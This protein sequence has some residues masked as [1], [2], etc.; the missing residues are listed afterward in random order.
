MVASPGLEPGLSALRGRR[1]NQLH[2]DAKKWKNIT[3]ATGGS[4]SGIASYFEDGSSPD[5][6]Q[7]E[8]FYLVVVVLAIEDVPLLATLKD[9]FALRGDLQTGCSVDP[10]LLQ[11]ELFEC[12]AGLLTD[13]IAVL[14]EVALADLGQGIGNGVG[15]LIH[16]VAGD[17]HNTAL[18]LR[19]SSIFTFLNISG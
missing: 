7:A 14:Q 9:D 3:V 15:E 12:L 17:P 5:E 6:L 4:I 16:L 1:V 19:A 8:F 18:Y 2:H 13:G 11:Q 10:H